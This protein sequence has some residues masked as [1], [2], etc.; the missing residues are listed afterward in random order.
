[1]ARIESTIVVSKSIED[2][3]AF[4]NEAESHA[5]FIPNMAE[6]KQTSDGAFGKVGTTARGVLSYFRLVKVPV[7][8]EI[9]EFRPV[10]NLAMKGVMG[11]VSFKDVYILNQQ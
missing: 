4:L 1:M 11:P 9:I 10:N 8:Y 7:E 2:T 6:L 5:R 3:F